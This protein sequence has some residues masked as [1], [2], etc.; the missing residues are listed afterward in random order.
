MLRVFS[1]AGLPVS[2]RREDGVVTIT[3]PLP[4]DDDGL[5]FDAY[6][7][8]VAARERAAN[9]ASLRPVFQPASV[10]VIGAAGGRARSAGRHWR[11]SSPAGTRAV[12]TRSTRTRRRSRGCPAFLTSPACRKRP[13]SRSWRCRRLRSSTRPTPA[14]ASGCAGWWCSRPAVD[15]AAGARLLAVCRRYGMRLIGPNCFGIAVPSIGLDATFAAA[16]PAPGT[17]GL[18]MQSGGLGFALVD[19]LRQAR[20]RI[21]SFASVGNK[22]DV[23]S[24]DMLMWWERDGDPG[25]RAL[26]RVVRQPAQVRADRAPGRRANSG[27]HGA[28]RTQRPASGRR[29]PTRR[30]PLPRWSPGR[31]CSSRPGS[32]PP[33]LRRADGGDRAARHPAAAA[34]ARSRSSP[35]SAARACSP[36]TPAPTSGSRSTTRTARPDGYCPPSSPTAAR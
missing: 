9:V 28:R 30:P 27:N 10:A 12:S 23:S 31:R 21:S 33:E 1:D 7:D 32:S 5:Q 17:A 18:V 3:I 25:G 19:H 13:T 14:A 20:D 8:T 11:T 35:T 36:P 29:R 22:L 2:T 24:N 4:P 34:G 26:H 6:L 16:N 15:A